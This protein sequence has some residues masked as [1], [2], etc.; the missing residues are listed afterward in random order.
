MGLLLRSKCYYRKVR[1]PPYSDWMTLPLTEKPD[2]ALFI[3]HWHI[4]SQIAHISSC[5]H[6]TPEDWYRHSL[7]VLDTLVTITKDITTS[8]RDIPLY[9]VDIL[10]PSC[11]YIIISSLRHIENSEFKQQGWDATATQL[12]MCLQQYNKRWD[13][14]DRK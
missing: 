1:C 14:P 4:L 11:P 8:Q 10:P 9:L 6:K 13:A 2:R 7:A 3:L 12:R 5:K